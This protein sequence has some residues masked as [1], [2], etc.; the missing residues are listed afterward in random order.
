VKELF[1]IIRPEEKY[2]VEQ[3]LIATIGY[4]FTSFLAQGRGMGGGLTYSQ[5]RGLTY[6][7]G[8]GL[9]PWSKS[10]PVTV[11][12][13]KIVYYIVVPDDVATLVLDAVGGAMRRGGGPEA[14]GRGLGAISPMG[15]EIPIGPPSLSRMRSSR[16][17]NSPAPNPAAEI[18]ATS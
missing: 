18:L 4:G 7:Q 9:F 16:N 2:E 12:L 15:E 1:L 17:E 5:G 14:F 11:F 13:P 6:S 3:A 8:R 10:K